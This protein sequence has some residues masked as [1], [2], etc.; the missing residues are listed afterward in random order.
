MAECDGLGGTLSLYPQEVDGDGRRLSG[1][2]HHLD[3][4]FAGGFVEDRRGEQAVLPLLSGYGLSVHGEWERVGALVHGEQLLYVVADRLER[5]QVVVLDGVRTPLPA[6][7]MGEERS[8]GGHV[9]KAGI[10]FNASHVGSLV[11]R[12]LVVV[13]LLAFSVAGI[14]A[15]KH[16]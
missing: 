7:D 14:F 10:A 16:A 8:V 9:Y 4:D 15:G 12:C 6:F 2:V 11:E 3:D 13:P 5:A 1:G